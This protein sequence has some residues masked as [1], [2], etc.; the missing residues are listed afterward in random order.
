MRKAG[1]V[2]GGMVALVLAI[3]T[4]TADEKDVPSIKQIMQKVGGVN[5]AKGLAAKCSDAAKGAKWEDAQKLSK[6]LSECCANLPMHKAPKGDAKKWEKL[7]QQFA[8]QSKAIEK[9]AEDKDAKAIGTELGAF[10]KACGTCH[11][12]YKG[13]KK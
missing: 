1:I 3:G 5:K 9:A 2:F 8:E 6:S 13:K 7:A 4:A 12:E 11:A 10:F